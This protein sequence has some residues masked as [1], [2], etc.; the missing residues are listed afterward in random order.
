[1]S[2]SRRAPAASGGRPRLGRLCFFVDFMSRSG[3]SELAI[4]GPFSP[5]TTWF[6]YLLYTL[7]I[8][9]SLMTLAELL[10]LLRTKLAVEPPIVEQALDIGPTA[11]DGAIKRGAV[12][13][14]NLGDG[15]RLRR[16]PTAWLRA[17]LQIADGDFLAALP[18]AR[19]GSNTSTECEP[20]ASD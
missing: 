19:I 4:Y 11:L 5:F 14:V 2:L 7:N 6:H 10:L 20:P 18:P 16:I 15:A 3:L 12:P 9:L 8:E 17:Q 13:V 1:M